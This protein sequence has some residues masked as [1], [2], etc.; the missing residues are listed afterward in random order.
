MFHGTKVERTFR[1]VR[2]YVATCLSGA[3]GALTGDGQSDH[4][5]GTVQLPNR[6]VVPTNEDGFQAIR[7]SGRAH[8]GERPSTSRA[9]IAWR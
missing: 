1:K 9:A 5:A 2:S 6:R 4:P 7:C 3:D 8:A